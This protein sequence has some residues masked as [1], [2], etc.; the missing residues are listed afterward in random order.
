MH[1]RQLD[2]SRGS[3]ALLPNQQIGLPFDAFAF[4][5]I[6]E[7]VLVA[8]HEHNDIRVLLDRARLAKMAKLGLIVAGRFDLAIELGEAK[9]RHFE[10]SSEPF[11]P[12]GDPRE[13]VLVVGRAGYRVQ[14]VAGNR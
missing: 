10:F 3:I 6:A 11:E 13:L 7:I 1:P 12:P 8:M 2:V 9:N 5:F 14:S 4:F